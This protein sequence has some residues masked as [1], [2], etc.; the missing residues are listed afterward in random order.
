MKPK[1]NRV[2]LY[3]QFK[4]SK[5]VL[6][7]DIRLLRDTVVGITRLTYISIVRT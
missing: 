7:F 4:A 1:L 6:R 2:Y 3:F 5:R